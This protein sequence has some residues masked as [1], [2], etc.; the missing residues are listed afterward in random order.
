[1]DGKGTSSGF[2]MLR[3]PAWSR[4]TLS[5]TRRVGPKWRAVESEMLHG[6]DGDEGDAAEN[7]GVGDAAAGKD[8]DVGETYQFTLDIVRCPAMGRAEQVEAAT[9]YREQVPNSFPHPSLHPFL[10][11][12]SPFARMRWLHARDSRH[13]SKFGTLVHK[14]DDTLVFC[15][16]GEGNCGLRCGAESCCPCQ[17]SRL[18]RASLPFVAPV[19]PDVR[20]LHRGADLMAACSTSLSSHGK[21]EAT[22]LVINNWLCRRTLPRGGIEKGCEG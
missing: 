10:L 22:A 20:P 15:E 4:V 12:L 7:G 8:E 19:L 2:S 9:S 16:L 18:P 11:P 14:T 21:A 3:G 17:S 6:V 13:C 5:V 1:M